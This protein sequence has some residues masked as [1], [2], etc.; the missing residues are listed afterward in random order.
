MAT[1]STLPPDVLLA[2]Y[3]PPM[4]EI[5]DRLRAVVRNAFPDALER[6]RPGWQLIGYDQPV[7]RGRTAYFAWVWPQ[8][9]HV[10][11]GFQRGVLMRDP[12]RI[13]QG[14]GITKQVRWLT[15]GPG[16]P[17]EPAR[18]VPLL[19]E[20]LRVATLTSAERYAAEQELDAIDPGARTLAPRR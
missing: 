3:P 19:H 6:V 15:F 1:T 7:G 18:L 10:H 17:I 14:R 12:D 8:P 4:H 5:A 20:A 11:L 9:E 16:D 13:L 2:G